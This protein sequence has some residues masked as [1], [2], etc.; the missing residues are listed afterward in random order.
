M[1]L[2]SFC[3][4]DD[5]QQKRLL[6]IGLIDPQLQS[7]HFPFDLIPD[8]GLRREDAVSVVH[9]VKLEELLDEIK[10]LFSVLLLH[11]LLT[12]NVFPMEGRHLSLWAILTFF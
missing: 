4:L 8:I 5:C 11:H 9:V 3:T 2:L 12:L 1:Q 7:Q 6:G 10:Q